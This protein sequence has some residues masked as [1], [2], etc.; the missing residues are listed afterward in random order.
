MLVVQSHHGKDNEYSEMY[1]Y[2]KLSPEAKE[3]I[4]KVEDASDMVM[5]IAFLISLG[6]VVTILVCALC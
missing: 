2:E 6:I 5:A 1:Y 4:K 3:E